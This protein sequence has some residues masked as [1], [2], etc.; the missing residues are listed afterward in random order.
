MPALYLR[1]VIHPQAHDNYRVVLN[2]DGLKIEIGS[3]GIQHGSGATE[4]WG[5]AIDTV[6]PMREAEAQGR[7]KD[8]RDCMR[9]F[10][11]AWDTASS[12]AIADLHFWQVPPNRVD[13]DQMGEILLVQLH[14]LL[15]CPSRSFIELMGVLLGRLSPAGWL[16]GR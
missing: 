14:C 3:I 1:K 11:A 16:W 7:G 13:T 9:Q 2:D 6:I 15:H 5:W 12:T 8:R 4:Y 10:R